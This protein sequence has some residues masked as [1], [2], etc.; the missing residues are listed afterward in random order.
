MIKKIK[1]SALI[2]VVGLL[3]FSSCNTTKNL[4]GYMSYETE[5]LGSE[6]D[7]SYTLR[8]WGIGRNQVD[9]LAQLQKNALKDVIFK[10]ISKGK[11][12]CQLKPMIMEVNAYEKYKSYFDKFFADKGEYENYINKKDRRSSTFHRERTEDEIKYGATVR[13]LYSKLEQKLIADGIIKK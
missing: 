9:A 13:V 6:L 11:E 12:D 1:I 5:C 10:G 4:G 3:V 2:L 8:A 7:G